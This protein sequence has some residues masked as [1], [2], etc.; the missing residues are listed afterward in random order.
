MLKRIK[1]FNF[2]MQIKCPECGS[3]KV[4]RKLGEVSCRKCGYVIDECMAL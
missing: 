4:A 3:V 1:K 2:F